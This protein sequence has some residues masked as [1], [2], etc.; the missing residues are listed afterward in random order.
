MHGLNYLT[1]IGIALLIIAGAASGASS[2]ENPLG[3]SFPTASSVSDA[4]LEAQRGGEIV[5]IS[6][7]TLTATLGENTITGSITGTN[8]VG[9]SAF[10][11][12][13]GFF[14]VIQNSGN[15]VIIQD[16]TIINLTVE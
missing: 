11:G 9:G 4:E 13:N 7:A 15:Q 14:T 2:E 8:S 5:P 16:S 6:D 3:E 12:A 10:T 1:G